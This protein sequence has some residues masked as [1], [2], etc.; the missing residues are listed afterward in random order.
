[1][2]WLIWA[3]GLLGL[4]LMAAPYVLAHASRGRALHEDL[5]C[6]ILLA[7]LAFPRAVIGVE[8]GWEIF[9]DRVFVAGGLWVLVAPFVLGYS[10]MSP[11]TYNDLAVGAVLVVLA[12]WQALADHTRPVLPLRSG[13]GHEKA[14]DRWLAHQGEAWVG[15]RIGGPR[16]KHG[17]RIS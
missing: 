2:R 16:R 10:D 17:R 14:T 3:T 13:N 11:T 8:P 12:V 5:V 1:M 7:G 9:L 6:G 4:W 15:M